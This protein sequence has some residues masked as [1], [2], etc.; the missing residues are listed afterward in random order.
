MP[1][2]EW[3]TLS[4]VILPDALLLVMFSSGRAKFGELPVYRV[5]IETF[6]IAAAAAITGVLV[7]LMIS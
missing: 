6:V 1:D 3:R 7:T 5:V 2:Q 4:Q